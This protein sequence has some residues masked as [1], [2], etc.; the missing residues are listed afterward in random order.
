VSKT[1]IDTNILVYLLDN[2]NRNK[3]EICRS[4]VK[5]ISLSNEAVISNQVLQEFYV[6]TTL[7]LKIDPHLVKSI[8]HSF[9][10]M[11]IISIGTELIDEAIDIN[12]Q[13]G[14]SFWDSLI[15]AAAESA[16]C[17]KLLSED[18]SDNQHIRKLTIVNPFKIQK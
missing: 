6:V 18:L 10:N 4:I 5:E 15:I 9:K 13:Y 8:I 12:I 1:F 2:R 3:Q 14:I 11:E 17:S 7:K 16:K